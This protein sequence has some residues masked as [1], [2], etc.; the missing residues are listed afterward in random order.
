MLLSPPG[1]STSEHGKVTALDDDEEPG[2]ESE[3]GR[4][5]EDEAVRGPVENLEEMDI[6]EEILQQVADEGLGQANGSYDVP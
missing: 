6:P 5:S 1:E 3:A 2:E 4:A